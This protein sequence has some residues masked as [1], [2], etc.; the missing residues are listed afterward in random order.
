MN[1]SGRG[2]TRSCGALM[3][4]HEGTTE[5]CNPRRVR[6]QAKRKITEAWRAEI[7]QAWTARGDVNSEARLTQLITDLLP[8]PARVAFEQA[9]R[10][11]PDWAWDDGEYRRDVPGGHIT[12]RPDTGELEIT[13]KLSVAIEAVGSATLVASGEVTA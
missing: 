2:G 1:S 8:E 11:A 4:S 10:V 9:M 6:V 5:M 12:Y 13:I 7:E 3:S